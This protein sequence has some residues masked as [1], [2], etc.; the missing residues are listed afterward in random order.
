[1]NGLELMQHVMNAV[2]ALGE[3]VQ[4][5]EQRAEEQERCIQHLATFNAY[6]TVKIEQMSGENE[7]RH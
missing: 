4:Q 5:L 3:R 7:P 6:M 1:M 2:V